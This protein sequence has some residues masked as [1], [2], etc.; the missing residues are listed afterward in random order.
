MFGRVAIVP[1]GTVGGVEAELLELNVEQPASRAAAMKMRA[2]RAPRD[3][4]EHALIVSGSASPT[5]SGTLVDSPRAAGN[6]IRAD[7]RGRRAQVAPE[8]PGPLLAQSVIS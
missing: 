2:A 6:A 3:R 7:A 4:R 8:S 1:M 5:L